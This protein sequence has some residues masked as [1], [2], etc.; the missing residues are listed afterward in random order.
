MGLKHYKIQLASLRTGKNIVSTGGKVYVAKTGET[1]KETLY[2][3][4]GASATNP[5]SITNG[6]IEFWTADTVASVD[7]YGQSPT[8]HGFTH[9]AEVASGLNEIYIDTNAKWT[10]LVIP[11][12][13]ADTTATT[14]TSTGFTLPTNAV[15]QPMGIGVDVLTA[16]SAKTIDFGVLSSESGGV[17]AGFGSAVSLGTAAAVFPALTVTAGVA[18]STTYGSLLADFTAGANSDDRGIFNRKEYRCDGT[19]HTISYTLSSG[20]TTSK[21]FLK[22]PYI[23]PNI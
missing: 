3:A 21:G 16:Q 2:T 4:A 11:F 8:G 1:V 17:A 13:A 23:I 15:V 6:L 22:I 18:A 19:A 14:E 5:V 12:A 10:E 20:S 9:T 7:L